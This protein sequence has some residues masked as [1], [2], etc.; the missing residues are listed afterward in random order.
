MPNGLI[1]GD[2]FRLGEGDERHEVM[3]NYVDSCLINQ[4]TKVE[5]RLI[6]DNGS[7]VV[8]K[9]PLRC[10]KHCGG[11]LCLTKKLLSRSLWLLLSG[12]KRDL[13]K[14]LG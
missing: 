8:G 2:S 4:A 10:L 7:I 5:K 13:R 14:N 3:M 1:M 6:I 9:H 11:F 12:E